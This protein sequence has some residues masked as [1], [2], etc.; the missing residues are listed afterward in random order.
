MKRMTIATL[1]L[2]VA[3]HAA[4]GGGEDT[5]DYRAKA[6]EHVKFE[7]VEPAAAASKATEMQQ[8]QPM[9]L[10]FLAL[11]PICLVTSASVGIDSPEEPSRAT[12]VIEEG[13]IPDDDLIAVRHKLELKREANGGWRIVS[14]RRGECRRKHLGMAGHPMFAGEK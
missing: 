12:V 3:A 4:C 11:K 5:T 13:G 14:Y 2:I 1:A 10:A 9:T 7:E 6:W 8:S